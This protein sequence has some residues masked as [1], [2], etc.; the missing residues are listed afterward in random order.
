[1]SEWT[2]GLALAL[3]V[4]TLDEAQ[5]TSLL[6]VSR[7]V[8]HRVE[9]KDTPLS[10]YLAGLAAGTSIAGGTDPADALAAVLETLRA[11]LP[12]AEP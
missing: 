3:G 8:A 5:E 1:M 7:E 4:R 2:D 11:A 9:R 10:A 12:S 6:R